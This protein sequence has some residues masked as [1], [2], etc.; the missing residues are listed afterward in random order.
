M[1]QR[2]TLTLLLVLSLGQVLLI[3]AQVQSSSG[4]PLLQSVA[5]GAFAQSQRASAAV[6]D[7]FRGVWTRYFA[8]SGVSAENDALRLRVL[9]LEGH[10]QE[11]QAQLGELLALQQALGL[12][13][14][15]PIATRAARVIAGSPQPGALTV[16]IDL[17]TADGVAANMAVLGAAGVVGRVLPQLSPRAAQVQLLI[18]KNAAAGAIIERLGTGGVVRGGGDTGGLPLRLDFV[19]NT[20]DVR[21]GDRV[22]TSG[23][24]GVYPAG[25]LIG[26]IE[27]ADPGP[28]TYRQIAVRPAVDFSHIGVVL[29]VTTPPAPGVGAAGASG[30]GIDT[31]SRQEA[32]R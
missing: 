18:G 23:Q 14:R 6:A 24:D 28:E 12:Q 22:L 2:R 11:Q 5:F 32:P 15:T 17:G 19:P 25:F 20:V 10:L 30:G 13:R 4:L 31:G 9:T 8:L 3:S 16:T 29:V 27:R 7:A 21:P 1:P 26:T